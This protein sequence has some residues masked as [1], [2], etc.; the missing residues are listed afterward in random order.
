MI[1]YITK[2][3]HFLRALKNEIKF[4]IHDTKSIEYKHRLGHCMECKYMKRGLFKRCSVCSCF[5]KL[6]TRFKSES[7]PLYIW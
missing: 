5:I 3:C 4:R 7:C 2:I 1:K 6:K